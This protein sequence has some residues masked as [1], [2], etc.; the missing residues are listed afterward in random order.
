MIPMEQSNDFRCNIMIL[1]NQRGG[2]VS[3]FRPF[4]IRD[5]HFGTN[6]DPHLRVTSNPLIP[7]PEIKRLWE[8]LKEELFQLELELEHKQGRISREEY[9]KTKAALDQTL[10][11]APQARSARTVAPGIRERWAR[12]W[13]LLFVRELRAEEVARIPC[14]A[15][16]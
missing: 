3:P 4:P 2:G 15:L 12:F 14:R 6:C 7:T 13:K 16:G 8:G 9:E 10:Q 11:R 5:S 1:K